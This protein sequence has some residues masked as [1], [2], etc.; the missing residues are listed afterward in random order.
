MFVDVLQKNLLY[1]ASCCD[2]AAIHVDRRWMRGKAAPNGNG[3]GSK[4][5]GANS[6]SKETCFKFAVPCCCWTRRTIRQEP[7]APNKRACLFI[8]A[9]VRAKARFRTRTT[10]A[11]PL[12]R[13]P[14][15]VLAVGLAQEVPRYAKSWVPLVTNLVP[16]VANLVTGQRWYL[17]LFTG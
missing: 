5:N 8:L 7:V 17:S 12:R 10:N 1:T 3:S 14:V 16:L 11:G 2:S 13:D 15:L 6:V 9:L 4:G